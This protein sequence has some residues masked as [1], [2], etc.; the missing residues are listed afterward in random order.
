MIEALVLV[1]ELADMDNGVLRFSDVARLDVSTKLG[2]V[3]SDYSL[4]GASFCSW[5]LLYSN[6]SR[7]VLSLALEVHGKEIY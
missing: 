5:G 2:E 6:E 1:V 3:A 4:E 7:V